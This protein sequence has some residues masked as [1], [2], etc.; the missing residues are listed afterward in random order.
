MNPSEG[1]IPR[2]ILW[3]SYR[4]GSTAFERSILTLEGV[5]V[6]HEYFAASYMPEGGSFFVTDFI[7][8]PLLESKYS[9]VKSVLEG[10][11]PG[12]RGVFLKDMAIHLVL[13]GKIH[14]VPDGYCH[15]ILI[16]NP[17]KSVTSL[18]RSL[19]QQNVDGL[20]EIIPHEPG[21]RELLELYQY[22]KNVRGKTPMVID[23]DDDLFR[24]PAT[25]MK[26]FCDFVGFEFKESMLHWNSDRP[27]AWKGNDAWFSTVLNTTGFL[28]KGTHSPSQI[29]LSSYP[30]YVRDAI[31]D[32]QPFYEK[33]YSLRSQP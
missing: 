8:D 7:K 27:E 19:S 17:V 28:K 16:R 1:S 31:Q 5:K 2:G 14:F 30:A 13:P 22:I 4:C 9:G 18:Y 32:S 12:Y 11:F 10:N 23:A 15:A 25:T 24:D 26:K 21:F 20:S 29:D 6:F 33:L 3:S